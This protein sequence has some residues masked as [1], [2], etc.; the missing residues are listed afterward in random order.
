MYVLMFDKRLFYLWSNNQNIPN[1]VGIYLLCLDE[2]I[3]TYFN[4]TQQVI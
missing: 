1:N 2:E 3:T 4:I